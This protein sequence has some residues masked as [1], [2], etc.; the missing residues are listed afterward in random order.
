LRKSTKFVFEFCGLDPTGRLPWLILQPSVASTMIFYDFPHEPLG[1]FLQRCYHENFSGIYAKEKS[2]G[3]PLR[4]H[5]LEI[6]MRTFLVEI[7]SWMGF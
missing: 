3:N 1:L 4:I 5:F 6:I 7:P 2:V